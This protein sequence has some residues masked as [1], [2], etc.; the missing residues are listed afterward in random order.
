MPEIFV[1]NLYYLVYFS[2]LYMYFMGKIIFCSNL[3]L[4]F[5]KIKYF[6]VFVLTNKKISNIIQNVVGQIPVSLY[7]DVAELV[8]AQD[9]KSCGPISRAGSIPAICTIFRGF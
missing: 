2:F 1:Y 5:I 6:Y 9:L 4:I 7:A 3:Q 8:D